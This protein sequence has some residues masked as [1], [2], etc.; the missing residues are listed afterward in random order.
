MMLGLCCQLGMRKESE[1]AE[2][3]IDRD[4]DRAFARKYLAIVSVGGTRAAREGT[5]MDPHHD[6]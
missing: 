1:H 2:P 6:G 4:H 3:I 5:S